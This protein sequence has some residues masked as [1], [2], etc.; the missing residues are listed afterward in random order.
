MYF[1]TDLDLSTRIHDQNIDSAF[2]I[3]SAEE[4]EKK[5]IESILSFDDTVKFQ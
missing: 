2:P 1:F 4:S 3:F 5:I